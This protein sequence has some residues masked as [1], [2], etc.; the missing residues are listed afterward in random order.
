METFRKTQ[1][2]QHLNTSIFAIKTI[3]Q[4]TSARNKYMKYFT[5]RNSILEI[6]YFPIG[7]F[8]KVENFHFFFIDVKIRI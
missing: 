7:V 6:K 2:P 8:W 1:M 3:G 5:R 4:D